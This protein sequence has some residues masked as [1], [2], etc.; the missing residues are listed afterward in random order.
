MHGLAPE[1]LHLSPSSAGL[2]LRKDTEY[3][4]LVCSQPALL[5]RA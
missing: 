2:Y 1:I 4:K 3:T 5:P